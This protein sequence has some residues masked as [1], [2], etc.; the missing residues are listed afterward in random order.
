MSEALR[1]AV[2]DTALAM[3]AS[4]INQGTSGNVSVRLAVPDAFLITPTA[5]PYSQLTPTAIVEMHGVTPQGG[6]PSSEWRFHYDIYQARPD[7]AAIVHTHSRQATA[8][9]CLRQSIPAFHYM[10]ACAGGRDIRC[11]DYHT[12]GTQALSD[13]VLRALHERRACLMANH[14]VVATGASLAAAL[15]LAIE[16]ENLAAMYLA[17]CAIGTPVLLGDDEMDCVLDKF[18]HYRA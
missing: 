13:A 2:I 4:G 9:A 18:R 1:Q 14:G 16:V 7:V 11:C 3:N 5:T 15:A 8:L 6:R 10:V 17:A 12:F